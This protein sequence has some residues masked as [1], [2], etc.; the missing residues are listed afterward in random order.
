MKVKPGLCLRFQDIGDARAVGHLSR[1]AADQVWNQPKRELCVTV[2]K[3]ERRWRSEE[4][5]DIR[6]RDEVLYVEFAQLGFD[7]GLVQ[8]F[9]TMPLYGKVV[10]ILY[11]CMLEAWDLLF[12]FYFIGNYS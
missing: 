10:Y 3:A 4:C 1:R 2:A 9:F 8:Y 5:L 11:Y 7:L 6:H 12:Y